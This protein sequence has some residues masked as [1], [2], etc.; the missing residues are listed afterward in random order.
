[1]SVLQV[2]RQ[3]AVNKNTFFKWLKDPRFAAEVEVPGQGAPFL[4]IER[5]RPAPGQLAHVLV[6]KYGN[7]L[8][9]YRQIQIFAHEGV[10]LDRSIML[11]WMV[12]STALLKLLTD[13][14]RRMVRRWYGFIADYTPVEMQASGQKKTK[15][16]RF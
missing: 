6:S 7:Q 1:M 10:D 11:H 8:L 5:K 2:A 16:A 9:L 3:Q 15:T 13:E 12:R 14:I 4:P